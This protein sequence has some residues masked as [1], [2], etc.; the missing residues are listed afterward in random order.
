MSKWVNKTNRGVSD[1]VQ[2]VA[3]GGN[4][5][6]PACFILFTCV[7]MIWGSWPGTVKAKTFGTVEEVMGELFPGEALKRETLYLD[8]EEVKVIEQVAGST[9]SSGIVYRYRCASG[10]G[11]LD[12]HRVRTLPET[13]LIVVANDGRVHK[14]KV[15]AFREPEEYMPDDRWYAQ[16]KSKALSNDLQLKRSID[17]KTGAT[18]TARATTQAVRRMLAVH[19]VES[20]L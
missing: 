9:L 18:L 17:G 11:Y 20:G 16:F 8:K 15:L 5:I 10:V 1:G 19:Q 4:T 14:V 13:L 12:S 2:V 7:L 6:R 3:N